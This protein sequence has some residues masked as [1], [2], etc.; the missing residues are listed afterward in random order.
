[1]LAGYALIFMF[2]LLLTAVCFALFYGIEGG[3]N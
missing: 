1:M 2:V 3:F